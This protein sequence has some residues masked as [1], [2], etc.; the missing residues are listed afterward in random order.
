MHKEHLFDINAFKVLGKGILKTKTN[1]GD[2][3]KVRICYM[4]SDRADDGIAVYRLTLT[5]RKGLYSDPEKQTHQLIKEFKEWGLFKQQFSIKVSTL[6]AMAK[7]A[8]D[9][10]KE[11][12]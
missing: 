3:V 5:K 12:A 10:I 11:K 6:F 8:N 7:F 1:D 4:R 2:L 9:I